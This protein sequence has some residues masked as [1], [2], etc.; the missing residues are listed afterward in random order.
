MIIG[1]MM[2]QSAEKADL[3]EKELSEALA[4]LD[5]SDDDEAKRDLTEEEL[6]DALAGLD[7]LDG[8]EEKR[9]LQ[10]KVEEFKRANAMVQ[11]LIQ[12]EQDNHRALLQIQKKKEEAQRAFEKEEAGCLAKWMTAKT[13]NLTVDK[14]VISMFML[15]REIQAL[16]YTEPDV[17]TFQAI[18]KLHRVELRLRELNII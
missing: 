7:D 6:T 9:D 12:V 14:H 3:T 16:Q 15:K 10:A 5:D 1:V 17:R 18:L 13:R 2:I 4:G 8:D 11:T